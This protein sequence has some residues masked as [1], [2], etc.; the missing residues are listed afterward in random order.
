MQKLIPDNFGQQNEVYETNCP[1]WTEELTAMGK[2]LNDLRRRYQ[3]TRED[4]A[5]RNQRKRLYSEAKT[6]YAAKIRKGKSSSWKQYCNMAPY[7]NPWNE[8][9]RFA[10]GKRKG[11]TQITTLRKPDGH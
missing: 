9:Y 6:E 11:Q 2:R 3:R 8:V 5:T 1:W 10:A 4:E 7:N